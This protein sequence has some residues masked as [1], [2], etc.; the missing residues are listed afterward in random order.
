[1]FTYFLKSSSTIALS[2][3]ELVNS[4]LSLGFFNSIRF[5]F[6]LILCLL[7]IFNNLLFDKA[8]G[9]VYLILLAFLISDLLLIVEA[10]NYSRHE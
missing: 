4:S 8:L 3:S 6:L 9:L 2:K 7:T 1:M 10:N 5:S